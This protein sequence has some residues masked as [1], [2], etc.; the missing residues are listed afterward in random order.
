[1]AGERSTKTAASGRGKGKRKKKAR[2]AKGAG[3]ALGVMIFAVSCIASL[4]LLY[5]VLLVDKVAVE[6]NAQVSAESILSASGIR[7]GQHMFLIDEAG[8]ITAILNN[9]YIDNVEIVRDYPD[10]VVLRIAER[11][12]CALISDSAG[13]SVLID[14]AGNVL[15]IGTQLSDTLITV[16]GMGNAGYTLGQSIDTGVDFQAAALVSILQAVENAGLTEEIKS[17]NMANAL[18]IELMT[19]SGYL[20]KLGQPDTLLDKLENL[21]AVL[22]KLQAEGKNGG[23]IYLAARSGPVYSPAEEP[24]GT[25]LPENTVLPESGETPNPEDTLQ[26]SPT[27]GESPQASPTPENGDPF[28][29]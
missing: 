28:S 14:H 20:V 6:G 13:D 17:V 19:H 24:S 3:H 25:A 11:K 2:S 23:T 4:L 12:P 26:A 8:A 22:K 10:T 27:P 9:P 18:S 16:Y 29:G 5:F 15:S 7:S 1:M 21:S